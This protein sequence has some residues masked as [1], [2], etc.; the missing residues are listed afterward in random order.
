MGN[1]VKHIENEI[2]RLIEEYALEE[3]QRQELVDVLSVKL[4]LA[5][6]E[7]PIRTLRKQLDTA[8]SYLDVDQ[9]VSFQNEIKD[10]N[11]INHD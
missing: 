9:Y 11:F 6:W 10:P 4:N 1:V 7:K 5:A 3:K 8:V 2:M